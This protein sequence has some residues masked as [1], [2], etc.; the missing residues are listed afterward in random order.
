MKSYELREGAPHCHAFLGAESYNELLAAIV[1]WW[2]PKG[3]EEG[4]CIENIQFWIDDDGSYNCHVYWC[5]LPPGVD[6]V[7]EIENKLGEERSN[8]FG[9]P[10][11]K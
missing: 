4:T 11:L 5:S 10:E 2:A 9:L 6:I 7:Q 1:E 8:P 3:A